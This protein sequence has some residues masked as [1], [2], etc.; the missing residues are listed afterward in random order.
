MKSINEKI[1]ELKLLKQETK[2][3]KQQY[4]SITDMDEFKQ[5]FKDISSPLSDPRDSMVVIITPD[6]KFY[7]R[8]KKY[9]SDMTSE[10]LYE[11]NYQTYDLKTMDRSIGKYISNE[12]GYVYIRTMVMG[13]SIINVPSQG[14]SNYQCGKLKELNDLVKIINKKRPQKNKMLFVYNDRDGELKDNLDGLINEIEIVEK[15]RKL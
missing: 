2:M 12:L 3:L 4:E 5:Y 9:H 13:P 14:V 11:I 6:N 7:K 8:G 15:V 1:T 10:L